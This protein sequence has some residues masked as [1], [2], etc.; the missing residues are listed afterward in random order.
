MSWSKNGK[1]HDVRYLQTH[2]LHVLLHARLRSDA[3][4]AVVFLKIKKLLPLGGL[5]HDA[6]VQ[7][8]RTEKESEDL[9]LNTMQRS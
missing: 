3:S 4:S 7:V 1:Y 6:Q 9:T 8:A 2:L 5:A